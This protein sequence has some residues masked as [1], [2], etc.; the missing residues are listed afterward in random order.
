[1]AEYR[2]HCFAESGNAY[3][4]ALMLELCGLDWQAL[5][6]DYFNGARRSAAYRGEINELG[7][8]PVLEHEGQRLTQSGVILDYLAERTGRFAAADAGERRE[9]W[10]WIL[11]DNHKFTSYA[12]THR[13]LLTFAKTGETPVTEFLR[14]RIQGAFAIADN[15]LRDRDFIIGKKPTIADISMC[16][17]LFY[18]DELG[19]S[20]EPYA[21]LRAWLGRIRALPRWRGP[22]ELLPK[23]A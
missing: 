1:M 20:L 16:G 11:F 5:W 2:L 9:I 21:Q 18:G 13:F 4:A 10:R 17:Y 8:V 7:E 15:H 12:A 22:Y 23:K 6:V 19:L 14:G 3:K